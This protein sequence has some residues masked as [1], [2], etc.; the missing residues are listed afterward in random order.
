MPC[1]RSV[2]T[3]TLVATCAPSTRAQSPDTGRVMTSPGVS[4]YYEKVGSG[5]HVVLIPNRPFMPEFNQLRQDDRTLVLYDMRNRGRSGRVEDSSRI[6]IMDDVD[7]LE[8]LRRHVGAERVSLVGYSYLGLMVALYATRYPDRVVRMVQVGPVPR[9]YDTAFP[10]DQTA[11][12][13]TLSQAALDA[14]TAWRTARDSATPQ[15]NQQDLCRIQRRYIAFLLVGNPENSSKVP[16][17]C[18]YENEWPVNQTRHLSAHFQDIQTRDFPK[19][20]FTTLSHPVLVVHGLLDRNAPYGAGLEWAATF[21]DAR[22]ITVPG[23]AHQVWLDDPMVLRDIDA[24]LSGSW[25]TR[26]V[27]FGR[28]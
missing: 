19:A 13:S 28:R 5:P 24:F 17:V 3:L 1:I 18:V 23:G 25:P 11:G 16:D 9:R 4:I 26:A 7:D 8:S 2:L 6:T 12:A 14:G 15:S 10:D 22:L 27:G 20:P 21:R